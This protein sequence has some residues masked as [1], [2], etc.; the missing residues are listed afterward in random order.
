MGDITITSG[1]NELPAYL[2]TPTGEGPW[3]GVVVIHDVLGMS[4]DLRNHADW[5]ASAGYLAIAPDLMAWGRKVTCIQT[6]MKDTAARNGRSFDDIE[7]ARGWLASHDSCTGRVGVI[8]F[9]MGGGFAM[10]LAANDKY[11]A[12]SVNYGQVPK[13]AS[14][15]FA[16]ACPVIGSYGAKDPS[17]KGA[18][19]RLEEAL[20]TAGVV[21]DVKEYPEAGHGFMGDHADHRI[22]AATM[23][24]F[25]S[26][27][28][29]ESAN[30]ARQ[31]IVAFFAEH[32][33]G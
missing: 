31:R 32:L 11:A 3:P 6:I 14:T 1:A 24:L 8:G 25:G 21:H 9:C 5:L 27:P 19:A 10:L 33:K 30:D 17:L 26:K 4:L 13:D 20:T 12:S 23:K 16:G 7:A 22:F 28:H 2:A 15:Y 29:A 18:A